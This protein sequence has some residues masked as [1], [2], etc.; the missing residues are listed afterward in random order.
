MKSNKDKLKQKNKNYY[1][2]YPKLAALSFFVLILIGT[3]LLMLPISVKDGKVGFID[4]LLTATSASCVT[5]LV[6]FDTFT[7][8]TLFGQIVILCLIQ[9][10]GL[11][12][13]TIIT[14]LT[15]FLK[16][17]L[18]LKEKILFK[19]SVGSI[20][21]GDLKS[22]GRTVLLG[23]MIFEIAGTLLLSTQFIPSMGLKNGIYTSVFLSVSA[24]CNAGFDVMGR[25]QESSSLV[26]VNDNPVILITIALLII[27]GGIG[28]IVWDD[29]R[30]NKFNFKRYGLHTKITLT[31]TAVLLVLSTILYLVFEWSNTLGDMN[32]GEKILNAFFTATT[33]RT[34]GFNSVPVG[35]MSDASKFTTYFLMFI[36]GSSGST[37]GGIK[38]STLAVLFLSTVSTLKNTKDVSVF[39][40]RIKDELVRKATAIMFINISIITVSSLILSLLEPELNY[41]DILFECFSAMGTVGMTVGITPLLG[42]ASRIIITLLMF[43][44]RVSS[45]TF[46]LS[47]RFESKTTSTQKPLGNMLVG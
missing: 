26:T 46:A 37:A 45:L 1:L 12:F 22:L 39:G 31:T 25:I 11:G 38:T 32:L 20:F 6:A 29:I 7:K 16:T 47:F 17:H 44:G 18:S 19:E 4:A 40:K 24:F 21:T 13:I 10:G 28:F 23:T 8:W 42:N 41:F 34:A 43:V 15:R 3:V 27:I 5:G 14:I 30:Y 36:G 9:I 35:D 33:T 2:F